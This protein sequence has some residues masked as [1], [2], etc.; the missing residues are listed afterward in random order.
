MTT[1]LL[2]LS[3]SLGSCLLAGAGTL[4]LLGGIG[5]MASRPAHTAGG[6]VPVTVANTVEVQDGDNPD[7][8]PFLK[9]VS[10]VTLNGDNTAQSFAVPA[11]KRLVVETVTAF[12]SAVAQPEA[13]AQIFLRASVGGV[14]GLYALPLLAGDGRV[15]TESLHFRADPATSVLVIASLNTPVSSEEDDVTVSG[16]LVDAP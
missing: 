1:P 8:Q 11:G 2:S 12:R 7:R 15:A 16:Y 4:A 3:S 9:N 13:R 14:S 6:P 5:L 10:L